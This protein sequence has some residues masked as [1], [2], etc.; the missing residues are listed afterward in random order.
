MAIH[1]ILVGT[2]VGLGFSIGFSGT[3][4]AQAQTQILSTVP[5]TVEYQYQMY[6]PRIWGWPGPGLS[7]GGSL[8]ANSREGISSFYGRPI[9]APLGAGVYMN[10]FAYSTQLPG[11]PFAYGL[12]SPT[13]TLPNVSQPAPQPLMRTSATN[14]EIPLG[15]GLTVNPAN[16]APISPPNVV[17]APD[18]ISRSLE[19]QSWGDEN[20]KRHQW[21][22]AYINF[23][24]AVITAG[25]RAD[26]QVRLGLTSI[27]MNRL[28][29][30][31]T[32]FKRAIAIDPN[33]GRASESLDSILGFGTQSI[34]AEMV[35]NV[36]SWTKQN[37][38]D[39][40]RLFLLGVVLLY[41][42][43]G[44][45]TEILEAALRLPGTKD[46]LLALTTPNAPAPYI[47]ESHP[48]GTQQP[49][50]APPDP[51]KLPLLHERPL[52]L[53]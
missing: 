24:N 15:Q 20:L 38:R 53:H 36:A 5:P 48:Q 29:D 32:A 52:A 11:P 33:T 6:Y 34:R 28:P 12:A 40:D 3:G 7:L 13:T 37:V 22:Q 26:L 41:N 50:P 10:P 47:A 35:Q 44:R 17:A 42:G 18:A 27:I 8:P 19:I 31:V 9:P 16:I 23:R 45:S 2:I 39:Q 14:P 4:L 51:V 49:V 21:T 1:R 25:D 46:H 30:A 43:D